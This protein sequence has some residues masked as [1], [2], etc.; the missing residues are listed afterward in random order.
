M[1]Q[2][3]K[4]RLLGMPRAKE[5]AA[6]PRADD[7]PMSEL[8]EKFGGPGVSDEEFLLRY[9]MKGEQE[10][11]AMRAAGRPKQYFNASLPLLTLLQELGK[12]PRVR[13]VEVKRGGDSLVI[14]NRSIE[15]CMQ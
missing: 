10:V 1:D 9:V 4:D 13:Y 14:Q 6:R 8:R 5:L 15:E 3:L 11:Q 2:N 12:H 7:I